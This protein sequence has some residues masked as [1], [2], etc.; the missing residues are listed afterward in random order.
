MALLRDAHTLEGRVSARDVA[1][2]HQADLATQGAASDVA[3]VR[4]PR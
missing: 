1:T 2:A 3:V 4:S